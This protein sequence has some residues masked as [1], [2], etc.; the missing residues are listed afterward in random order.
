MREF[1]DDLHQE[2]PEWGAHVDQTIQHATDVLG[3]SLHDALQQFQQA[4]G[5]G[6]PNAGFLPD[7][8]NDIA[9]L[10]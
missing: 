7:D 1:L 2:D 6:D 10:L 4:M 3:K 8:D 5:G 9:D